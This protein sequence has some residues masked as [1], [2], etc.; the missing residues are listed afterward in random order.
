MKPLL[1]EFTMAVSAGS[2]GS[3]RAFCPCFFGVVVLATWIALAPSYRCSAVPRVSVLY[4]WRTWEF[5]A[6]PWRGAERGCV[7]R[8]AVLQ[9]RS[10]SGPADRCSGTTEETR[11]AGASPSQA[12]LAAAEAASVIPL[13]NPRWS[14]LTGLGSGLWLA[15]AQKLFVRRS[16]EI[17]GLCVLRW[18]VV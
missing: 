10:P 5:R 4:A 18:W 8:G 14:L 11:D 17:V 13:Y 12:G 16:C 6:I 7:Q 1:A 15:S 9:C 2:H 3:M